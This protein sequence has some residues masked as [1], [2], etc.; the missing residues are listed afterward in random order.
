MKTLALLTFVLFSSFESSAAE[1]QNSDVL[2]ANAH[3]CRRAPYTYKIATTT[4][5]RTGEELFCDE[6]VTVTACH[7]LCPSEQVRELEPCLSLTCNT[8]TQKNSS[9]SLVAILS[10]QERCLEFL[11]AI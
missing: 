6:V 11:S 7:G 1:W 2:D 9:T 4:H 3:S 10:G 5:H 8:H